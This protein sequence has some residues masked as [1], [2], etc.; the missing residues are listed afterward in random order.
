[1]SK[2]IR[3]RSL[4]CNFPPKIQ[5]K[6]SKTVRESETPCSRTKLTLQLLPSL[7]RVMP[8]ITDGWS[9]DF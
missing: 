6:L 2:K 8:Y 9:A 5:G 1:M 3:Q 7:E 4:N